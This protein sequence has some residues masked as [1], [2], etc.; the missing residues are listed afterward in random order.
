MKELSVNIKICDRSYPMK[1]QVED[2]TNV[3]KVGQILNQKVKGYRSKFGIRDPQ[4]LLAMVAFDCLM[5]QL[6]ATA[7]NTAT[8]DLFTE[9]LTQLTKQMSQH[10]PSENTT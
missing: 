9:Q 3:R 6:Q 10:F 4:D 2:E 5:E 1:V 7:S 8:T